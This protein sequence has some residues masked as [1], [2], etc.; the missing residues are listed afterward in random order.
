[1][2]NIFIKTSEIAIWVADKYFK[3]KDLVS[4]DEILCAL[5]NATDDLDHMIEKYDDLS[6]DLHDN[7]KFVGQDYYESEY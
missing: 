1:M 6:Q 4:I 2:N 5:E 3:G 7:Y